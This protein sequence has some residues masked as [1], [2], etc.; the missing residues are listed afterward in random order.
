MWFRAFLILC[1][2]AFSLN[3]QLPAPTNAPIVG[4]RQPALSPDG[5]RLAFVYRGD[6][7]IADSKGGRAEPLT[8][9]LETDAYPLFSPDGNW[10]AFSSRRS[11]NW[12]I[13]VVPAEGGSA[14]QLTWHSGTDI[15]QGWS[16]DGKT[17]LCSSKRDSV[18]YE[19]FAIDVATLGTKVLTEDYATMNSANFSPDGKRVIYARYGFPWTRP[20]YFGSAAAE[21]WTLDPAKGERH[22]ITTNQFQHLWPRFTPDGKIL[23]VTCAERTPSSSRLGETISPIADN[24]LRTP[25]LWVVDTDGSARQLTIFT[26]GAV[27]WPTVAQK[28]GDIAFEY[29]PDLYVLRRGTRDPQK[30]TLFAMADEKQTTKRREKLTNGATEA[31]PSPDGKTFAFGLH[32]DIWT[33]AIDKPKGIAG[34]SAEYATRLTD[35]AGEDSDFSW[36]RDGK[37]IYFTSDRAFFTRIYELDVKSRKVKP[38]WERNSDVERLKV[39]PDG[40]QLGFWVAGPEGGLYT[41]TLSNSEVKRIVNA[42]GVQWRGQG[43]GDFEWSPDM[44]WICYA[45]RGESKAWNLWIVQANGAGEPQNV[46][47]LYAHHGMPAW[48]PDGK[49]I[50]FQSNRDSN[51]PRDPGTLYVLPLT[52]EDVRVADTDLKFVKPTNAVTVKI[53]FEDIHRRIRKVGASQT[54]QNDLTVTAE[55]LIVFISDGDIWSVTYDGKETKRL[56]SGGN[57]SQLR[58]SKDGKTAFFINNG[59][60]ATMKLEGGKE[61]KVTFS[62]DWER[63]VRAERLASFTQFWRSYQ[64]GFYDPN[65]HGRNWEKI[66]ER[67]EPLLDS[68][69]TNDEF[70]SL[71][72]MMIG[73]LEASHAEVSAGTNTAANP[74]PRTPHLGFTFD[75]SYNGPGI[76]VKSVPHGAPGWY[77]KTRISPGDVVLAI[78]GQNVSL[79]EELYRTINDK[80]DRD[81]EFLVSTNGSKEG[82]RTV[83]YRV[84]SE[85][86]WTQVNYQNRVE[87]LRDYVEAKSHGKI[88]YLHI[89]SMGAQN[90][91]Q[92]EREAYEYIVGKDAMIIDVRFNNGGNI[93]DTLVEWLQRKPHGWIRPRDGVKEPVPFHA[94]DRK[95]VVLQNEHSYSNA[96]IF[97]DAMR[98]RGLARLIG[99]PTPG[100]VIWTSSLSLVDGTNARMPMTGHYRLDGT[101]IEN[102]GEVPDIEVS[103][104][105]DDWVNDRDPQLDKAIEVLSGGTLVKQ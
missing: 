70:A 53:E 85:N 55:G 23:T 66:R 97:P 40:K 2:V 69:D 36:S 94:W 5:T 50:F 60:L 32:G 84:L 20:R 54:P 37:K 59:E 73:E 74:T 63:D 22:A 81:F 15:P 48:S 68:V 98:A 14:R 9:H 42:P 90:Q 16:P 38:L 101:P 71:L 24:P 99:R 57:K 27:R 39:S 13:F 87:R 8:Q 76:K 4:A 58:V 25:N 3:A 1:A 11:G 52:R 79:N 33:V 19:L 62:A 100:Y 45:H 29:G 83:R 46:T 56:T 65:F 51:G 35:W 96:E 93:A 95:M 12:D 75:Y 80:Q 47:R 17:L 30:L 102:N 92:F 88:G 7:W 43:G 49:Y 31:E 26:G 21:I 18:N 61:T 86:E 82:A 41:L 28:N 64:R 72:N 91:A 67:Y 105:P 44:R 103:L 104:T 10:I 89:A 6:L 34:R 77:H 78:N